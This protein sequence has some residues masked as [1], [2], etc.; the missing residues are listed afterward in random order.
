MFRA[1]LFALCLVPY[2]LT[3]AD[4]SQ[5]IYDPRRLPTTP[6]MGSVG[7]RS[8]A[9]ATIGRTIGITPV[10]V[11]EPKDTPYSCN[12][13]MPE[14][15]TT[16]RCISR[17]TDCLKKDDVCGEHFEL[18]AEST[19]I[20]QY[21]EFNQNKIM[22]QDVLA[23]CPIDAIN[24]LFGSNLGEEEPEK[25]DCNGVMTP[26]ARKL[27]EGKTRKTLT[28]LTIENESNSRIAALIREGNLYAANNAVPTCYKLVDQCFA[29]ACTPNPYYC[30]SGTSFDVAGKLEG[31]DCRTNEDLNSPGCYLEP[32]NMRHIKDFLSRACIDTVG[33]SQACYM[34]TFPD[35]GPPRPSDLVKQENREDIFD[36]V[37][38]ERF[39]GQNKTNM[40]RKIDELIAQAVE[41]ARA[42]CRDTIVQCAMNSCAE[43]N[44][45]ACY[46]QAQ[47]SSGTIDIAGISTRPAIKLGCEGIIS[48]DP[49][50]RFVEVEMFVNA[51]GVF[52][53][54]SYKEDVFNNL[55]QCSNSTGTSPACCTTAPCK[56]GSDPT[57]AIASLNTRLSS[58]FSAGS[59]DRI[60]QQ[61]RSTVKS[62]ITNRCGSGYDMCYTGGGAF[63]TGV[64][65]WI[66]AVIDTSRRADGTL[67]RGIVIGLCYDTVTNDPICKDHF[68]VLEAL[69]TKSNTP[70]WGTSNSIDNAWRSAVDAP[71]ISVQQQISV[72]NKL[73]CTAG[74]NKKIVGDCGTKVDPS[75][76][77]ELCET[78]NNPALE[79]EI[80]K[81]VIAVGQVF[82]DVLSEMNDTIQQERRARKTREFNRC[83]SGNSGTNLAYAWVKHTGGTNFKNFDRMNYALNGLN[84][85]FI[86]SR[87]PGDGFCAIAVELRSTDSEIQKILSDRTSIGSGHLSINSAGTTRFFAVGDSFDCGSWIPEDTINEIAKRIH[88][89]E[90][91]DGKGRRWLTS[92]G[93]AALTGGAGAITTHVLNNKGKRSGILNNNKEAE[94]KEVANSCINKIKSAIGKIKNVTIDGNN[95]CQI[96]SSGLEISSEISRDSGCN[97]EAHPKTDEHSKAKEAAEKLCQNLR[98]QSETITK[99]VG[100]NNQAWNMGINTTAAT[101]AGFGTTMAIMKNR[102]ERAADEAEQKWRDDMEDKT[103]CYIGTQKVACF[104]DTVMTS[105]D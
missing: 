45:A 3:Q 97:I 30:K 51:D 95:V 10:P 54:F 42:Q 4:A 25:I 26:I 84:T 86:E 40:E 77:D 43:G 49:S 66:P 55:F 20:D 35:A 93:V 90:L 91:D 67:D 63:N 96:P 1:V 59:I 88:K 82:N 24:G 57:G 36:L 16:A 12:R 85:S 18:C 44:G 34:T 103:C 69:R 89:N 81:G 23:T 64:D 83:M 65:D 50:C 39:I 62:C 61:C 73:Q 102:A 46:A 92:L 28:E 99:T 98:E 70:S 7:G 53:G 104:G 47:A 76:Q 21:K 15:T 8:I 105:L 9:G 56:L 38:S 52:D 80:E 17:Y 6:T 87:D 48:N 11:N 37:F 78:Y 29:R 94:N 13:P 101:L 72:D 19:G 58:S 32:I 74:Y 31:K 27:F 14:I 75:C 33:T 79:V 41:N 71:H 100:G 22:C 2:A 5:L 60:R 68:D